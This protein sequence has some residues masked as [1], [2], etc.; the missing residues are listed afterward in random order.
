[1]NTFP[2]ITARDGEGAAVPGSIM[3]ANEGLLDRELASA[4]PIGA[5]LDRYLTPPSDDVPPTT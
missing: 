4:D 3:E 1:M 2:M 5:W